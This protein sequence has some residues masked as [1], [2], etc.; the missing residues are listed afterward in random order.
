MH[1]T[2]MVRVRGKTRKCFG[3][4][5]K[6]PFHQVKV[7]QLSGNYRNKDVKSAIK[8]LRNDSIVLLSLSGNDTVESFIV[9]ILVLI[10]SATEL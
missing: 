9:M 3:I 2:K 1:F 8:V 10:T 7:F 5:V 6:F 4:S